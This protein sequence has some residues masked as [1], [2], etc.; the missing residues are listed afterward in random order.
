MKGVEYKYE[1]EST[2]DT[3]YLALKGEPWCVFCEK[4]GENPPH[5]NG[6]TL[7]IKMALIFW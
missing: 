4:F 5:Y 6:T 7:Y 2:K 1:I 3:P